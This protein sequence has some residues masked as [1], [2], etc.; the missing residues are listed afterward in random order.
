LEKKK[1]KLK[2]IITGRTIL[3]KIGR[4]KNLQSGINVLPAG[5]I[6]P[7]IIFNNSSLSEGL[8]PGISKVFP[9]IS[10]PFLLFLFQGLCLI[11]LLLLF[12]Y[13]LVFS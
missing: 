10:C 6:L 11:Y 12:I 8:H 1:Q 13:V 5:G 7:K 4:F 9:C 2:K 3:K